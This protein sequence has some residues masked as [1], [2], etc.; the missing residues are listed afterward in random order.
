[1][2]GLGFLATLLPGDPLPLLLTLGGL[3]VV[4]GFISPKVILGL[5]G[6]LFLSVLFMPFVHGFIGSLSIWWQLVIFGLFG[7]GTLRGLLALFVSARAADHAAGRLTYDL[8]R[9]PVRVIGATSRVAAAA[10]H[11]TRGGGQ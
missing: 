3:A 4:L 8:I 7:L 2:T 5:V 9:L 11:D 10:R 6:L 1:M